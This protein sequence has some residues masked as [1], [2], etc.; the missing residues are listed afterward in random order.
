VPIRCGGT[1]TH[2]RMFGGLRWLDMSDT[3][4]DYSIGLGVLRG[5]LAFS[6][7]KGSIYIFLVVTVVRQTKSNVRHWNSIRSFPVVLHTCNTHFR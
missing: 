2:R 6:S 4:W 5:R 1:K 7:Q 3:T